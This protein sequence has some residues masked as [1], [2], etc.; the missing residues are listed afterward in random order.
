MDMKRPRSPYFKVNEQ[1]NGCLAC[2]QNCP[3]NALTY[4]D[5]GESRILR[6]NMS[7]C[8]RCGNCWRICPQNAIQF[9]HFLQGDWDDVATMKLVHCRVCGEPLYTVNFEETL[10]HKLKHDMDH[11]CPQHRQEHTISA[12]KRLKPD[13]NKIKEAAL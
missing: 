11:L 7:R 8:A 12:W 5:H 6:H 4:V 2:V 3:A 9:E 13:T 1:C 10:S